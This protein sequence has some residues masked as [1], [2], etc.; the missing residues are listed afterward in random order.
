M[1]FN[2]Y[3]AARRGKTF[4]VLGFGVSNRPL[5]RML[6]DAGL[7]ITV[8]DKS[9][10][11]KLDASADDYESRGARFI[12]GEDY[13]ARLD[14]DVI[15]RTPGLMPRTAEIAAAVARG[16]ELT[17][18]MELFFEVCPCKII[19][20]TGSDGKTTTTT[21]ISEFLRAEG[22]RVWLGGNI[23]TPLLEHAGEMSPNDV[24]VLELSSF[25][26]MTF[27][28]SPDIA[29]VTNV[30][31]NHLDL[32]SDLDEYIAAKTRI[33]AYQNADARLVL[34]ADNAVTRG[35]ADIARAPITYFSRQSEPRGGVFTRNGTIYAGDPAEPILDTR[36]IRIHGIHNVENY[37]AAIAA[38]LGQVSAETVRRVAREFSGVANRIEF[39]REFENVRYYNDS[40]SSSPTRTIAGLR[41]FGQ[42]IILIA[43][44]K[45]KGIAYDE[46]GSEIIK[47]VAA[48]VITGMTADKIRAS[49][50]NCAEYSG[51][52]A[53]Y[54]E[55]TFEGAV[56]KAR[57]I[58]RDG[59]I[60]M[61][62][63]ASTSFDR[64]RNFEERGE[65][66][67]SIVW[68]MDN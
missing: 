34:N 1:T 49:V 59:D 7:N 58:A 29:V 31:P 30:T 32:H 63:P 19:A 52:P 67:K 68:A 54:E 36:E 21:L 42:K 50:E 56:A 18:E 27:T 47:H 23:G 8:R 48:L 57:E 26:L 45:D 24:A 15:F 35:F 51:S 16:A 44:G 20:V 10:R 17:S 60:V 55:P 64:F 11:G 40:A 22:K 5:V 3:C 13:L 2:E 9:E 37:C 46:I 4:A 38:T 39:V 66:F 43:G 53:I 65:Y 41:S 14:E 61:L 33:F 25:Q 62:S 6:L 12:C 28:R